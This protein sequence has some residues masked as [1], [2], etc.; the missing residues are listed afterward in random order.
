METF[1]RSPTWVTQ[2]FGA[3]FAGEHGSN[4]KCVFG[5]I[6]P[7]HITRCTNGINRR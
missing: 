6:S 1:V 5:I 4:V 2:P 7:P 3:I